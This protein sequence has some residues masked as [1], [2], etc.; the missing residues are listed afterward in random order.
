MHAVYPPG[1][2]IKIVFDDSTVAMANRVD[3]QA[4]TCY[5][6]SVPG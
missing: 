3:P 1:L 6:R 2:R 5:I 4:M